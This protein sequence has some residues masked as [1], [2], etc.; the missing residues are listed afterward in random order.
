MY[1]GICALLKQM[2]FIVFLLGFLSVYAQED[3]LIV[4]EEMSEMERQKREKLD[5]R[6]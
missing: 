6:E 3:D 4:L 2:F 5:G 1:V